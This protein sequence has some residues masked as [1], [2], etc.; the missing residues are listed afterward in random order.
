MSRPNIAVLGAG[1]LIGQEVASR[2]LEAGYPV[3]P[4]ARRFSPAQETGFADRAVVLPVAALDGPALAQWL[5]ERRV[6]L[7][8]NCLGLLQDSGGERADE[9]HRAFVGRL[10]E[11]I[12]AQPE[13]PLLVH[14][15]IPGRATE[16]GT[17]FSRTKRA[18]ER[19]I[20]AATTPYVILRP[21]FV[22][23]P[24]AYGGS[25][26]IRA[27]AALPFDLPRG[28]SGRP[29]AATDV[30]DIARTVG[31]LAERWRDG[32]RRFAAVWD[33][34][35]RAPG[36][37]GG[38]VE[39]FRRRFGGPRPVLRLPSWLM[40]LAAAAGDGSAHLGWRPP[41]RGTALREMR[42]GVEGDPESWIAATGLEPASLEEAL[43]HLAATVQ[44]R[45][46]A[47]LYL[48][49]ALVLASL[50]VF[51]CA[52]G[53]ISLSW[54]FSA[55][56]AILTT[57]GFPP[58]L[59]FWATFL[60]SLGDIAVGITIAFRRTSRVGLAAGIV[61]S[62]GYWAAAAILAPDLWIEPLG[63][64]VKTGPAMVL[65]LVALTISDDR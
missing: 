50:V 54:A 60:T 26:L 14:L 13:P 27:L 41:V 34:M 18:A 21:G 47:R 64:L 46:F 58:G 40:T 20:A 63:A 55:A 31:F 11:A 17:E 57:H 52:S 53:L 19:M 62:L 6:G 65:M 8:V 1:G 9:V 28:E 56:V 2:L 15:S 25:A 12:A 51:W 42:R 33:V 32:E 29:F 16:D 7:V 48:V 38:V 39:G 5:A 59:A 30:G 22:V 10:L 61:V 44:E 37:V 43:S 24:A 45:W 3:V 35:E 36:T 4:V 23:A 49:K